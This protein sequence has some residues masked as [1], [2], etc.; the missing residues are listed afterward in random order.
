MTWLC[1]ICGKRRDDADISVACHDI[2]EEH[3]L[4]FGSATRNVRYC[5]DSAK[6]SDLAFRPVDKNGGIRRGT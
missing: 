5:N 4:P 3:G 1:E 6:C 2:S